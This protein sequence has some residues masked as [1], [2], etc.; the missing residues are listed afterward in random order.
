MTGPV[1]FQISAKE[2]GFENAQPWRFKFQQKIRF[3]KSQIWEQL[4]NSK[5]AKTATRRFV[6]RKW[7]MDLEKLVWTPSISA[8]LPET[9]DVL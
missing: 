2:C 5:S 1:F 9:S 8:Q 7:E 4:P 3:E 6:W